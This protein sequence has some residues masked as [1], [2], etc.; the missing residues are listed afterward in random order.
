MAS[1][2]T[3]TS[4]GQSGQSD[5]SPTSRTTPNYL[6]VSAY[7]QH[8]VRLEQLGTQ[9][10]SAPSVARP[11]SPPPRRGHY[12]DGFVAGKSNTFAAA[13][14]RSRRARPPAPPQASRAARF[15]CHRDAPPVR[16]CG[17]QAGVELARAARQRDG[18][19]V[20]ATTASAATRSVPGRSRR[21]TCS[22]TCGRRC[23]RAGIRA[24]RSAC[25]G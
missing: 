13:S 12:L 24:G 2:G 15:H 23:H 5:L 25:S 10:C 11:L 8:F 21:D 18:G 4:S 14:L 7:I 17:P 1:K 22:G 19:L 6:P 3:S 9:R 16:G 20:A